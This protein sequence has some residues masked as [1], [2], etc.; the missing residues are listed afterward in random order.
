MEDLG[1]SGGGGSIFKWDY[2]REID[3]NDVF[4]NFLIR[5]FDN[6]ILGGALKIY[7][8]SL[9]F[10]GTIL[11]GFYIVYSI[12]STASS[13]K[14]LGDKYH[15]IYSPL[16][17]VLGFA[18]LLPLANGYSSI[19]YFL[20]DFVRPVSIN[21]ANMP[22]SFVAESIYIQGKT[23]T[24]FKSKNNEFVF[25]VF[26]HE[27]CMQHINHPPSKF[28]PYKRIPP[29]DF[30]G[31]GASWYN[32]IFDDK[33]RTWDYKEC[34]SFSYLESKIESFDAAKMTAISQLV[35]SARLAAI[36]FNILVEENL[37]FFDTPGNIGNEKLKEFHPEKIE[38]IYQIIKNANN[39]INKAFVE[40]AEIAVDPSTE[41]NR[42]AIVDGAKSRGF[43][44]MGEYALSLSQNS[45][46]AAELAN[47]LPHNFP[48]Q[49]RAMNFRKDSIMVISVDVAREI[50][51]LKSRSDQANANDLASTADGDAN[52]VVQMVAPFIRGL[53]ESW[54]TAASEEI[55]AFAKIAGTGETMKTIAGLIILAS[56]GLKI[57]TTNIISSASGVGGAVD[58]YLGWVDWGAGL[59]YILGIMRANVFPMIPYI[60]CVVFSVQMVLSYIKAL[61]GMPLLALSMVNLKGDEFFGEKQ[62]KGY[63]IILELIFRPVFFVLGF[64]ASLLLFD[65]VYNYM[66]TSFATAYF[67]AT[68]GTIP[69]PVT[70]IVFFVVET[71]VTWF[72]IFQLFGHI[73]SISDG[74]LEWFGVNSEKQNHGAE[75]IAAATAAN[76]VA[77]KMP[78]GGGG[79]S[80]LGNLG[81]GGKD[82]VSMKDGSNN[83]SNNQKIRMG[84]DS[85]V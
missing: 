80:P 32:G 76:A 73:G 17:I 18:L 74:I 72:I 53:F 29:P 40:G 26:E 35:S 28:D 84:N 13:G 3:A 9:V 10:G 67:G 52:A 4:N 14:V 55:S 33:K 31:E 49:Y 50:I 5:L 36:K 41:E 82:A 63:G 48:P 79:G 51:G 11:L 42:K 57:A 15:Q 20:K 64:I 27:L 85:N 1:N 21:L 16:R 66:S 56:G 59:L 39:N 71:V 61:I 43:M 2:L 46:K 58:Y 6:Q 81:G 25:D 65:I 38:E 78:S 12:I 24:P 69:S 7:T 68:G 23:L 22:W 75:V 30:E 60:M 19:H 83:S 8:T 45:A 62:S 54:T 47:D 70:L 37:T 44:S 34:G 77:N